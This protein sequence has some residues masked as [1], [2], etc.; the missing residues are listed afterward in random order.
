MLICGECGSPYRR[1]MCDSHGKRKVYWRCLNRIEHGTQ[2]CKKSIGIEECKLH[3]AICKILS[4][5]LPNR[6]EIMN[7]VI[8][9]LEYAVTGNSEILNVYNLE[10]NIRQLKEEAN[11][12]MNMAEK[13]EGEVERYEKEI[14][15]IFEKIKV[16]REQLN[17]AKAQAGRVDDM[18]LESQRIAEILGKEELN[19]NVYDDNIIRRIVECIKVMSDRTLVIIL[20]GGY[21]ISGTI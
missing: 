2:F 20:K 21:E 7:T 10:S 19:F 5:V 4:T 11:T 18:R 17:I 1:R 3:E 13:T 12:L 8:S 16:L 6:E 15:A 14:S 9:T